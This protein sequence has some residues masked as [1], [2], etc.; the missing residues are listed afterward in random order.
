M[1]GDANS[2]MPSQRAARMPDPTLDIAAPGGDWSFVAS[3]MLPIAVM[4]VA[5]LIRWRSLRAKGQAPNPFR[6]VS[7]VTG[8][9]V[10]VVGLAS[11]VDSIGEDQSQ[12][13]HMVQHVLL[14]DTASFFVVAGLTGRLLAPLLSIAAIH[15]L[16]WLAQPLV[17][18][19]IW[20]IDLYAWH[21]PVLY[22]AALH[23]D[24]IHAIEHTCM[25]AAG[26]LW[27]AALLEPLPGPAWF[28]SIQKVFYLLVT[29]MVSGL[30]ANIFIWSSSAFYPY[31]NGRPRWHGMSPGESQNLAG[32]VLLTEGMIITLAGLAWFFFQAL[33]EDE[34][35]QRLVDGGMDER[36]AARAARYHRPEA[37]RTLTSENR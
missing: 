26:C 25:F 9:A 8:L 32:I 14:G 4:L 16:R 24:T 21:A 7:F 31:Y 10:L 28:G 6:L 17:A 36:R 18:F 2:G 15:K 12:M 33:A 37:Q 5:Y 19:P 1:P 11:P 13:M 30:L 3:E 34:A 35:R 27:W 22:E 23:N 29:R 20:A